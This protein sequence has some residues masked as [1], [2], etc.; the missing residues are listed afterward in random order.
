MDGSFVSVGSH[1]GK[2]YIYNMNDKYVS[3]HLPL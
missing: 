1:R 2:M 3:H